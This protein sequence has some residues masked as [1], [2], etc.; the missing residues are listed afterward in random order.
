MLMSEGETH[1]NIKIDNETKVER[2]YW[3]INSELSVDFIFT[4]T[5]SELYL[6]SLFAQ[7]DL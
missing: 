2:R 4:C 1:T 6:N 3:W 7:I 5:L